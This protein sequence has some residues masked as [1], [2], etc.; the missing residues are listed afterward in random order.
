MS[1]CR[2]PGELPTFKIRRSTAPR[3]HLQ[4]V[5]MIAAIL[6]PYAGFALPAAAETEV[7]VVKADI[8]P[9]SSEF[10]VLDKNGKPIYDAKIH[11]VVRYGFM[12][13]KKQDL[14][15]GT[16]SDGKARITGL[17]SKLKR[18]LEYV[19]SSGQMKRSVMSD[20]G[21][22]CHATESVTL[23]SP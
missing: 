7:P 12:D 3:A 10:T 9:C 5:W 13:K 6:L 2:W 20:P 19:V 18:P 21:V 14:E 4:F 11:V 16:N 1:S 8:G 15:I 23:G 22:E 17:P